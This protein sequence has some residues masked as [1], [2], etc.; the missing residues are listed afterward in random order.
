MTLSGRFL[1]FWVSDSLSFATTLLCDLANPDHAEDIAKILAFLTGDVNNVSDTYSPPADKLTLINPANDTKQV[2]EWCTTDGTTDFLGLPY[3]MLE[4]RDEMW[5]RRTV[6]F[7][8]LA[9]KE[10]DPTGTI[11]PLTFKCAWM[12]HYYVDHEHAVLKLIHAALQ[13]PINTEA[14][15][16]LQEAKTAVDPQV[17]A[18]IPKPLGCLTDCQR[19]SRGVMSPIG[20]K[21]G[22]NVPSNSEK[23]VYLELSVLVT[24]G[25]HGERIPTEP[26]SFSLRD[27][28]D[29][30]SGALQT[31]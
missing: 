14:Y 3:E 28:Y 30:L 15:P 9:R 17:L 10:D 22:L 20:D 16:F 19:T 21:E 31:L 2:W 6:V 23:E 25:P 13:E 27:H 7:A 1:R 11:L 4:I 12:P 18:C 24:T 26:S 8:G 5:G 29:I